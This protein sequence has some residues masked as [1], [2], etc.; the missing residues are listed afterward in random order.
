MNSSYA[1]TYIKFNPSRLN[2]LL[3]RILGYYIGLQVKEDEIIYIAHIGM[4]GTLIIGIYINFN[5]L[6][7]KSLKY[8]V[9]FSFMEYK[10]NFAFLQIIT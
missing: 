5:R 3:K 6:I 7:I 2:Y 10:H 9:I 8:V 4:L 1:F